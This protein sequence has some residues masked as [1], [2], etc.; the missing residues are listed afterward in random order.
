M[1]FDKS[2]VNADKAATIN[3]VLVVLFLFVKNASKFEIR[4]M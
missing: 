1:F 4:E 2:C 3:L